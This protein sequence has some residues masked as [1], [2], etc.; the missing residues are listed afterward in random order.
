MPPVRRGPDRDVRRPRDVTA[1]RELR[2]AR[3]AGRGRDLLPPARP[4]VLVLPPRAAPC[5]RVGRR[6]LLR[7]R[8]LLGVLRLMGRARKALRRRDDRP[9]RAHSRQPGRRSR[10]QRRVSPP[11]LRRARH[12]RPRRRAGR[13]RRRGGSSSRYHDGRRIHGCRNRAGD[14]RRARARGPGGRQQRLRTRPR[15]PRF[16]SG[17]PSTRQ[18]LGS[19]DPR[20]PPPAPPHRTAAVRHH[21]S[22]ALLVPFTPDGLARARHGGVA[23]RRCR[24]A[25]DARRVL[26]RVCKTRGE[27]RRTEPRA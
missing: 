17:T 14:R 19:R 23:R 7:L 25:R 9:A 20:V 18:G 16:R 8:V 2:A 6:D 1:L 12:P 22:R 4:S 26:A 24:R 21:L 10:E 5:L 3:A 15:H 27:R 13:E 11:A